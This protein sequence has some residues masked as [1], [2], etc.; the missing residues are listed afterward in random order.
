M[1]AERPTSLFQHTNY[2]EFLCQRYAS[3]QMLI[4]VRWDFLFIHSIICKVKGSQL[5]NYICA[6]HCVLFVSHAEYF[7]EMD[8]LQS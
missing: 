4:I 6:S 3:Y 8:A 5:I 2:E 7:S 1:H